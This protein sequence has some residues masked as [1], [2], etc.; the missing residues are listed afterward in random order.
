MDERPTWMR[1]AGLAGVSL[2]LI[3]A[4]SLLGPNR[5]D[6][7]E[8][9]TY[10]W[11]YR[12]PR[13]ALAA[14]AGAGLAIGG[15]IFQALF[16]NPLAEPYT[17]GIAGGAALGAATGIILQLTGSWLGVPRVGMLALGGALVAMV[18]VMSVARSRAGHDMTRLLLAGVCVAYMCGAG[19][20]LVTYLADAAITNDIV[21]WMMGSLALFQ[22]RA[23]LEVLVVLLP[24]L[25][26]AIYAHRA[27]DLL[28]LGDHLAASRGVNVGRVVRTSFVLVGV[29]TAVIVARCGPIGFVGLMVPHATRRLVGQR[30]LPLLVGSAVIGAAFLAVCDAIARSLTSYELPVGILTNIAGAG[31][32][33]F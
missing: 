20:L 2:L 6:W 30:S 29:L 25:A 17:L 7:A 4:S 11:Q 18:L 19:V 12:A 31:F 13:T 16:R 1:L 3:A 33:F 9:S 14:V 15:V 5:L 24:V 32:F 23:P 8:L 21:I 27:L 10:Y 28:A 22:P 26:Y